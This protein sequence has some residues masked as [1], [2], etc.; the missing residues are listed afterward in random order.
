MDRIYDKIRTTVHLNIEKQS[1]MGV[2]QKKKKMFLENLQNSQE[3]TCASLS[4]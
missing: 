2:L 4:Y 1:S 3:N